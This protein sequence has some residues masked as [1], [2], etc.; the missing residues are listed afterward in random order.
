MVPYN[1][2][3]WFDGKGGAESVAGDAPEEDKPAPIYEASGGGKSSSGEGSA[4]ETRLGEATAKEPVN[5]GSWSV[6]AG[7]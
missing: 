5:M 1:A 6:R 2:K 7:N 4:N 3:V